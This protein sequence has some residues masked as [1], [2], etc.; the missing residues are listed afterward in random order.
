[1]AR[2]IAWLVN[3]PVYGGLLLDDVSVRTRP[4]GPLGGRALIYVDSSCLA[5]RTVKR[6][7]GTRTNAVHAFLVRALV[8]KL[9]DKELFSSGQGVSK[10]LA[11]MTPYRGQMELITRHLARVGGLHNIEATT[12][13]RLQGGE[14]DI[15][16]ADFTDSVG[17]KLGHFMTARWLDEESAKLM[18]VMLTRARLH[19]VVVANFDYLLAAAPAD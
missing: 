16:I 5:P 8:Q 12:A 11:V 13:H 14:R 7:S 10:T 3:E 15:I 1:M 18:N 4:R 2:D 19:L 6:E 9:A 17:A